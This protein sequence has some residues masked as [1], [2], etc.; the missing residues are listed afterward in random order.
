M[1]RNGDYVGAGGVRTYYEVSGEGEPLLLLH[2]GFCSAETFDGLTPLLAEAY[3]VYLPERRGHGRTPDVVGPITFEN[4]AQDTVAFM[5]ALEITSAHLVGWSDGAAVAL[6]VALMRPELVRKL[7]LIGT[8][9]NLDGLAAEAREMLESGLSPEIL[10]PVL[11]D[12]YAAASPDGA[13]HFDVVF[14]KL[15]ATWKVEPSF[16]L[17]EIGKLAMPVLVMLGD[18][19]M[20]TVEHAAAVQ[21]AITDAQLAVVPGAGHEFP[22][23]APELVSRPVLAFLSESS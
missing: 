23:V 4:M 19:D 18:R 12:L 17:S 7:V 5:E 15:S 1:G 3:R 11:R 9:V 21:R 22:M 2:G 13:E 14:E 6:H 10:P 16:E 8:A 20:V